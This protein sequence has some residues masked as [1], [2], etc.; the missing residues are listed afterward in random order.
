MTMTD[1][2]KATPSTEGWLD[3]L[4]VTWRLLDVPLKE[5]D[6]I[7]SVQNQARKVAVDPDIVERYADDM[8]A[9]DQFPP[10]LL[11]HRTKTSRLVVL[12]GNHRFAAKGKIGA[13]A[14]S[15]YVIDCDDETAVRITYEDNR[16]HGLPP[17]DLE[18]A[19]HAAHLMAAMG[20][21]REAAARAVGIS[22]GKL[23]RA[24]DTQRTEARV[25]EL[26]VDIQAFA[27]MPT[28]S[29]W[30][31]GAIKADPI[32]AGACKLA[33]DAK[34]TGDAI[35]KLVTA[36][37]AT[38]SEA[39]AQRIID[40]ERSKNATKIRDRRHRG[41]VTK[42]ARELAFDAALILS[43]IKPVDVARSCVTPAQRRE[44]GN[45]LAHATI[46]IAKAIQAL[47]VEK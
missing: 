20:W 44:L 26:G 3:S 24:I 31:L 25:I 15:G 39:D 19:D 4:G 6:P 23:N 38:R 27:Q 32:F 18:R 34:L 29:R 42:T 33:G 47:G 2:P 37:N 35:Y 43:N 7:R 17:S 46:V 9:G 41:R 13:E 16:R 28:T 30:R 36:L 40:A 21:K 10:I 8:L 22:I 1:T 45:L 5:V 11:H 12:G 14:I